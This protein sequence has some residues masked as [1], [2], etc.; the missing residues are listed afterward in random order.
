MFVSA[1]KWANSLVKFAWR[2]F[3]PRKVGYPLAPSNIL[4]VIGP[5]VYR[6]KVIELLGQP[7]SSYGGTVGYRFANALLQVNYEG[8]A[9]YSVALVATSLR[10]PNRFQVFPLEIKI[11]SA[12]FAD[13]CTLD[14]DG[15]LALRADHSSKFYAHW[16]QEYFGFPG[17]Y[18]HY[19]FAMLEA[20]VYPAVKRPEG[21]VEFG[22][23]IQ[24][25][26]RR[27]RLINPKET[28]FNAVVVSRSEEDHFQFTWSI[29][30]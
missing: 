10:W 20:A 17:R 14:D 27:N 4:E 22:A 19:G 24:D 25:E 8:D 30:S 18:M 7:H 6:E 15:T 16:R 13:V 28:R 21:N 1:A 5:Y 3:F 11:G 2:R 29:F 23:A 9:V 26:A 12:T